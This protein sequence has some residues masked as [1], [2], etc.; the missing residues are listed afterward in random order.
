MVDVHENVSLPQLKAKATALPPP[1]D[2]ITT[3]IYS[4]ETTSLHGSPQNIFSGDYDMPSAIIG[5]VAPTNDDATLTAG[6]ATSQ[7]IEQTDGA[8][9][10]TEPITAAL[11]S[12][13]QITTNFPSGQY[14]EH[15]TDT[16]DESISQHS[17]HS[18]HSRHTFSRGAH[19]ARNGLQDI[20]E[21]R[22]SHSPTSSSVSYPDESMVPA[23]TQALLATAGGE[24]ELGHVLKEEAQGIILNQFR[25]AVAGGQSDA[26]MY[27]IDTAKATAY[28]QVHSY[29]SSQERRHK[30][31]QDRHQQSPKRQRQKRQDTRD[32]RANQQA[33]LA[34]TDLARRLTAKESREDK[35]QEERRD[36]KRFRN[37]LGLFCTT[38][39]GAFHKTHMCKILSTR[40]DDPE[41]AGEQCTNCGGL[42]HK[43]DSDLCAARWI[44]IEG[45]KSDRN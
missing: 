25:G 26:V 14:R 15:E 42:Y 28:Q 2:A 30:R 9:T 11:D 40:K 27:L 18:G 37:C 21:S 45:L 38:C 3:D 17:E 6:T 33:K 16:D 32:D 7:A 22:R 1:M 29:P 44:L 4:D 8:S 10:N 36:N 19:R 34:A 24:I 39:Y 43:A 12:T 31:S 13:L 23:N 5:N 41:F 35:K 20:S